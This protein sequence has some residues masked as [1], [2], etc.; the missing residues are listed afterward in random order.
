MVN[1]QDYITVMQLAL[2]VTAINRKRSLPPRKHMWWVF[3]Y[4]DVWGAIRHCSLLG[5]K[6]IVYVLL[7]IH[8]TL[9]VSISVSSAAVRAKFVFIKLFTVCHFIH[10]SLYYKPKHVPSFMC[11]STMCNFK[12]NKKLRHGRVFLCIDLCVSVIVRVC[13]FFVQVS[14]SFPFIMVTPPAL[15]L[16]WFCNDLRITLWVE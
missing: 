3:I 12:W 9:N 5:R 6:T 13:V 8:V 11:M 2:G 15:L 14:H 4:M 10:D 16:L 7:F 1:Y